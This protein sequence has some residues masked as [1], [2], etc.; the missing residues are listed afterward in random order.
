MSIQSQ[1]KNLSQTRFENHWEAMG[2][3][4]Y[5]H[6]ITDSAEVRGMTGKKGVFTKKQPADYIVTV[7]GET[8]FAEVKAT[9]HPRH[10]SLSQI[11][12]GQWAA[13]RRQVAAG[14]QYFFFVYSACLDRWFRVPASVFLERG[15]GSFRWSE[16]NELEWKC[17]R[18]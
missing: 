10:F 16:L 11:E 17:T 15:S 8:F 6:R 14:G 1:L 18:T 2:K 13:A 9:T 5:C 12:P 3:A 7:G 4:A